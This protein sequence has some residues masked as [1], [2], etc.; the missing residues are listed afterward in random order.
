VPNRDAFWGK[1]ELEDPAPVTFLIAQSLIEYGM[2]SLK[3][4]MQL[5]SYSLRDWISHAPPATWILIG[6]VVLATLW[7]WSRRS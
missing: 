4:Q 1:V 2:V 3:T 7:A 6:V 5:M